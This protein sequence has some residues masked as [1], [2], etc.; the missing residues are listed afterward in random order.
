[1]LTPSQLRKKATKRIWLYAI[2]RV[3]IGTAILDVA[4]TPHKQYRF[5]GR[6]FFIQLLLVGA[7]VYK[8]RQWMENRCLANRFATYYFALDASRHN[9]VSEVAMQVGETSAQVSAA[10]KRMAHLG[11][12]PELTI[13]QDGTISMLEASRHHLAKW[14]D[15]KEMKEELRRIKARRVKCISCGAENMLPKNSTHPCIYC[16]TALRSDE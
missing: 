5:D 7:F 13:E 8:L 1:M 15:D 2:L 3:L 14:L 16:G 4:L 6:I 11:L 12:M 10:F 9:K